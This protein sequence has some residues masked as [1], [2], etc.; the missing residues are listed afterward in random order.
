MKNRNMVKFLWKKTIKGDIRL[1]SCQKDHEETKKL[2][3][4]S[5]LF[6]MAV[7]KRTSKQEKPG[8]SNLK[9]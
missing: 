9:E 1:S 7:N 4:V 2:V 8:K 5:V 3:A 6:P